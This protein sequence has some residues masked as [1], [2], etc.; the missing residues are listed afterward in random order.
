MH[1]KFIWIMTISILPLLM[2]NLVYGQVEDQQDLVLNLHMAGALTMG[3][4]TGCLF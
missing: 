4:Q 3:E 1:V 2:G